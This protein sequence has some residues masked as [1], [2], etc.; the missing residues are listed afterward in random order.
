MSSITDFE[1]AQD[2]HE[3]EGF[4]RYDELEDFDETPDTICDECRCELATISL[5]HNI[6]DAGE[7]CADC[8]PKVAAGIEPCAL[9]ESPAFDNGCAGCPVSIFCK[10]GIDSK[11]IALTGRLN[12]AV[13]S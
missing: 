13:A 6:G 12:V 7:L 1:R 10:A 9:W 3:R 2:A 8:F 5:I 4:R 11:V